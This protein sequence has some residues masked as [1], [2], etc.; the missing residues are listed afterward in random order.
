VADPDGDGGIE[1]FCVSGSGLVDVW[2]LA[3][4]VEDRPDGWPSINRDLGKS[5]CAGSLDAASIAERPSWQ[6]R[7][8]WLSAPGMVHGQVR[9]CW[10]QPEGPAPAGAHDLVW[11][12]RKADG[13]G[14][15]TGVCWVR[16]RRG[17]QQASQRIM[18]LR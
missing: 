11:P 15:A 4:P 18:I 9:L 5:R 12:A 2:D 3:T 7:L 17:S 8:R 16:L 14:C 1:I 10:T 6:P 13:R